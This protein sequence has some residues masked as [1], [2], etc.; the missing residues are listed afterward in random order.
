MTIGLILDLIP[1]YVAAA[2]FVEHHEGLLDDLLS[3]LGG[4]ELPHVLQKPA[5][6]E[7]SCSESQMMTSD[8]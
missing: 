8:K 6:V 7:D 4:L 1:L 3:L 2:I 5:V